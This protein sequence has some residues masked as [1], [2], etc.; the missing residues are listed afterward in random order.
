MKS[1]GWTLLQPEL[2]QTPERSRDK[3]FSLGKEERVE[4]KAELQG[5]PPAAG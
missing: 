1:E 4:A 2:L 3:V 5:H